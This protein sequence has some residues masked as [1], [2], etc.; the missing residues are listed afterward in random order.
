[1]WLPIILNVC[2]VNK[3]SSMMTY[4]P[5]TLISSRKPAYILF[6]SLLSLFGLCLLIIYME[7]EKTLFVFL[8]GNEGPVIFSCRGV[9]DS[10]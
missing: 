3:L 2:V 8:H 4:E 6:F 5:S 7:M 1:M 9:Q 10:T